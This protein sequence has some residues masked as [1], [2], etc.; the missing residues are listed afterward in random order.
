MP[1]RQPIRLICLLAAFFL[2]SG[3]V[4][5]TPTT[6]KKKR[7][8]ARSSAGLKQPKLAAVAHH[9]ISHLSQLPK[10]R[11]I[12]SPWSSPTFADSTTGDSVDGEDL[13][14]RRAAVQALGPY[15]GTVVVAD[16]GTGRAMT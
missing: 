6:H 2:V 15:N 10:K 8:I 7:R 1:L 14:V 12:N 13:V 4:F 3:S 9:P 5:G 11:Y 16:P